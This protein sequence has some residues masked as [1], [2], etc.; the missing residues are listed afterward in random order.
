MGRPIRESRHSSIEDGRQVLMEVFTQDLRST[1]YKKR[2]SGTFRRLSTF[3]SKAE[4]PLICLP[5][6]IIRSVTVDGRR[7]FREKA[8][9][10]IKRDNSLINIPVTRKP[11]PEIQLVA[12]PVG[13]T[14]FIEIPQLSVRQR[15]VPLAAVSVT[16]CK[17]R[18]QWNSFFRP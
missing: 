17:K 5:V 9:T 12:M 11:L 16:S 7:C 18:P 15:Q 3:F 13:S 8:F 14:Q 1:R 6:L 10:F 4:F 2:Q